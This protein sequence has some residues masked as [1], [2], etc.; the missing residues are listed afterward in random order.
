[1]NSS[2]LFSWNSLSML[3]MLTLAISLV[4]VIG[5]HGNKRFL[6]YLPHKLFIYTMQ[7]IC[8]YMKNPL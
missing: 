3:K 8:I 5:L 2:L 7:N 4:F 6:I 1:M